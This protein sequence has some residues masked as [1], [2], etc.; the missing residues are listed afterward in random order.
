MEPEATADGAMERALR[1]QIDALK[2]V[3]ALRKQASRIKPLPPARVDFLQTM[4]VTTVL[5]VLAVACVC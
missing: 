4:E 1:A 2:R 5:R 3:A